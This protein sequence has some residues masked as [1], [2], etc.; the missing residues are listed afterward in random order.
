MILF[1]M[2][3][4]AHD[5]LALT[6]STDLGGQLHREV[7]E[8]RRHMKTLARQVGKLDDRCSLKLNPHVVH[9]ITSLGVSFMALCDPSYPPV[10]AFSFL[11]EIQKEFITIYDTRQISNCVRPYTFIEFDS[12]IQKTRQRYNNP[13]SL[14]TRLNLSNLSTEIQLRPPQQIELC[15]ITP[16]HHKVTPLAPSSVGGV[17]PLPSLPSYGIISIV[18]SVVCVLF[19]L[20]RGLMALSE[21]SIEEIDGT[22]PSYGFAFLVE[23]CI[24][25]SQVYLLLWN[26]KKRRELAGILFLLVILCNVY[27][28][29]VRDVWQILFLVSV[30]SVIT[31]V[32][33][34]HQPQAKLPNYNV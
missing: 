18:L 20:Y 11:D 21:S 19:N 31:F 14:T 12:Y 7:Q 32:T 6:A 4:R 24:G 26:R 15:D 29:E 5:G 22:N 28:K 1:A 13:R 23:A 33:S 10:L 8:A 3:V 30:A 9:F 27:V 34:V 2:I 16:N 25:A 17:P